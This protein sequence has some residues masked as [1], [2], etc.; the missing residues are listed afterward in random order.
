MTKQSTTQASRP[1]TQHLH[2]S[3]SIPGSQ[4]NSSKMYGSRERSS[5]QLQAETLVSDVMKCFQ[6][7]KPQDN[8][9]AYRIK[10]NKSQGN[11]TSVNLQG[12]IL[13]LRILG[14]YLTKSLRNQPRRKSRIKFKSWLQTRVKLHLRRT[15]KTQ[16]RVSNL[17]ILVKKLGETFGKSSS[18]QKSRTKSRCRTKIL[19]YGVP[20]RLYPL[21]QKNLCILFKRT[22]VLGLDQNKV[23]KLNLEFLKKDSGIVGWMS[24][25][26]EGTMN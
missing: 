12:R 15:D 7:K 22:R 9:Y 3:S 1:S 4:I 19:K 23:S 21:Q 18:K 11:C 2:N 14:R 6:E 20:K 26:N 5:P 25:Q 10:S 24:R 16:G 8:L 17:R 13:N